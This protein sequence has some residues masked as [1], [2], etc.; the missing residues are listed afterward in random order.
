MLREKLVERKPQ[1]DRIREA[2]NCCG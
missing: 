1:L 2:F